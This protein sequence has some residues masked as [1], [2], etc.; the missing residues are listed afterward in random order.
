MIR[1]L[2]IAC[3][4]LL[5]RPTFTLTVVATLAVGI[6][7]NAAI[8]SVVDAVVLRP[9][10]FPDAGRLAAVFQTVDRGTVERRA[11]SYPDFLA[12]SEGVK[13]FEAM[14][15]YGAVVHRLTGEERTERLRGERVSP[16][17]FGILGSP[18]ALGRGLTP[19]RGIDGDLGR[20]VVVSHALW[21]RAWG[22]DPEILGRTVWLDDQPHTVVGVA[23]EGFAGAQDGAEVWTSLLDADPAVLADRRNRDLGVVARLAQGASLELANRQLA[24]VFDGSGE[25]G[26]AGNDGYG[27]AAV[28]LHDDRLGSLRRPVLLL[29][30]AVGL[31]LL[32]ACANVANLLLVQ[33]VRARRQSAI[34][35][36]LGAR[37]RDL[38]RRSIV[39]ALVLGLVGGFLG[40]VLAAWGLAGLTHLSPVTLPV[41]AAVDLDLRALGF[42]VLLA[43]AVGGLLGLVSGWRHVAGGVAPWLRDRS[44]GGRRGGW[45]ARRGLVAA[46]VALALLVTSGSGLMLQSWRQLHAVDPGFDT[47]EAAVL[48]FTVPG[49]AAERRRVHRRVLAALRSEPGVQGATLASDVPLSGGYR[50]VVVSAEGAARRPDATYGGGVRT[51]RHHV[52][53]DYFHTLGIPIVAGRAL[54]RRDQSEDGPT[55]AVVSRGLADRL[56]PGSDPIGKRF[57]GGVPPEP[58][59][60]EGVRWLEVVG[61]AEKCGTAPW[62]PTPPASPRIPTSTCPSAGGRRAPPRR[63]APSRGWPRPGCRGWPGSSRRCIRGCRSSTRRSSGT[64]SGS[65]PPGAVSAPP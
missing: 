57:K 38:A 61:V 63:W 6:G 25:G 28:S 36:A 17:Y 10:P 65:R 29:L 22:G 24:A 16:S 42:S 60:G 14:G 62:C 18:P 40:V 64:I 21:M 8:F 55:R 46:E 41:H 59:A 7:A 52:D 54:D 35:V 32:I 39:E 20:E 11:F 9:L 49:D 56:W 37:P 53:D 4:S 23:P 31:L 43:L 51:Y 19:R 15:A 48:R 12:A 3:R 58:G 34:C 13:G 2:R 30:G 47:R 33:A 44:R 27:A 5:R 26:Q 45:G 1:D 50:A